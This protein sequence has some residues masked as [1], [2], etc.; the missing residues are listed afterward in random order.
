MPSNTEWLSQQLAPF[1]PRREL[2]EL[3]LELNRLY[4]ASE[5]RDY[6]RK[7]TEIFRQLPGIWAGLID[8]A[9]ATLPQSPIRILDFG[10]GTGFEARQLLG[11]ISRE[12]IAGLCCYDLSPEM[13]EAAGQ[14]LRPLFPDAVLTSRW[15]EVAE[16]PGAGHFN[17]LATN[18]LLHHLPDIEGTLQQ[19]APLLSKDAVWIAGHEPSVRF[20]R[21]PQC[22]RVL[23]DF[24]CERRWRRFATPSNYINRVRTWLG[25]RSSPADEAAR[26][27]VELGLFARQPSAEVVSRLVDFH[28]PHS[29]A[30]AAAGRGLDFEEMA[31]RLQG[32]WRLLTVQTYSFMGPFYEGRLPRRWADACRDLAGRFPNDGSNFSTVWQRVAG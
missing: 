7:H 31:Q 9:V 11:R 13:L 6:D 8:T 12:R 28:V 16:A 19:I 4:H 27:S 10:C 24:R 2:P 14:A 26:K 20:Y 17:L 22:A 3:I 30:E 25:M 23:S 5:A 1:G 29:T 21:N 32:R 18:A 15:S